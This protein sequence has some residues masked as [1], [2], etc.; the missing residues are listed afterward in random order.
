MADADRARLDPQARAVIENAARSGGPA[1][2]SLS[3]AEARRLYRETRLRLAP[4]PV[5]VE[6]ARDFSFPGPAGDI[7]ARYY[8]PLG[9][10]AREA[11]PAVVYFHGGG[12]TCGDLDTHDS[13]CR[14]IAAHGCC[15]VVAV[16]YRMGPE[17]K[18]P[19]AVEDALAAVQWVCK[20]ASPFAIDAAR[21]AVAGES[22]GGNLAAVT[23]IALRDS[24]PGLAMQVLV[25]P[26]TD[27]AADTDSLRRFAQGYSLTLDLLRWYQAQY[28]RDERDRADWRASPL[29]AR[30][31]SR[32]PGAYILTAGF[33]PLLDEGLAYAERLARAGVAVT[34]ECFEGQIHG[35]LPMG[36]AIAAAHHAHYRIGQMLRMR[37]GTLP[38]VRP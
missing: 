4:P 35:F 36:G 8:R 29:R 12:W 30:E 21:L 11:L 32:L 5:A 25:Y 27:Q 15:A 23:A 6:E 3:V 16:D 1:L 31:H 13:V 38:G 33:D 19:A 18:F 34:Y 2:D 28:L 26:V 9:S 37:F 10:E 17:H 20:N 22:A 7:G 24:E 14:G